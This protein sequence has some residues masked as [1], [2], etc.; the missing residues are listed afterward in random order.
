[1]EPARPKAAVYVEGLGYSQARPPLQRTARPARPLLSALGENGHLAFNDPTVA[2]FADP[3]DVKVVEL[4]AACTGKSTRET[5]P[6]STTSG[7]GHHRDNPGP[8]PGRPVSPSFPRRAR[9]SRSLVALTGPITTACPA[10]TLRTIFH[11]AVYLEPASARL[12]PD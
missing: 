12:L 2:D 6:A 1:M 10:S 11:A 3:R 8:P 4:E 9:R 5:F 7:A